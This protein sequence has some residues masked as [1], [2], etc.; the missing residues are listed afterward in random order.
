V[1][2]GDQSVAFQQAGNRMH[3]QKALLK[4]LLTK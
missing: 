3:S 4:A 2:D 1:L